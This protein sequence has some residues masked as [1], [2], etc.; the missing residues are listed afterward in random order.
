[1]GISIVI[2][3]IGL[4]VVALLSSSE[5]GLISVNK[6]RVR[7]RAEAGNRSARAVME[8]VGQHEKFFA[9]I[10][11]TENAAIILVAT[12]GDRL[13]IKV[14][15]ESATGLVLATLAI[16]AL[17]V[18]FGEIT[19]KSLAAMASEKWSMIVARPIKWL[20]W[21]ET[22]L[23]WIFTIL[24]RLVVRLLGG[25]EALVTPSVTE[26]ELRM[27]IDLGES[28]G[29]VAATRGEMLEGVFRFGETEV[30]DVMTPRNEIVWVEADT[31]L[32]DFLDLYGNTQHTRFPVFEDDTDDVVGILSIKDVLGSLA[33]QPADLDRPVTRLMRSPVFVPETNKLSDLFTTLRQSG[34]KISLVVDEFGGI[35]GLVTLT[36]LVEQVVGRTGEEGLR[37]EERFVTIGED[38]Y[39][40]DGGMSIDEANDRLELGLPEGEYTTIAGFILE[41]LQRIPQ[42]GDRLRFGD[43]RFLV[44]GVDGNKIERVRV[45]RRLPTPGVQVEA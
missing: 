17:V 34:S 36:R 27:L 2:F 32:A 21:I 29:T 45:R 15:G 11:L 12:I 26:G 8:V 22:P 38:T 6:F 37:P 1:M 44:T 40:L 3:V 25:R 24:P 42:D 14:F 9:A 4:V 35:S 19:P 31:R 39:E 18:I 10:L 7:H 13:A 43:L 28:E 16:T 33:E 5:A 23:L 30:V 41:Q 20:L